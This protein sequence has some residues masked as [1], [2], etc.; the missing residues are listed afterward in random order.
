[1]NEQNTNLEN[2]KG[3][4]GKNNI[5]SSKSGKIIERINIDDYELRHKIGNNIYCNTRICKNHLTN[6]IFAM[7]IYKKADILKNKGKMI[8]HVISTYKTLSMASHPFI[9]ELKGIHCTDPISLYYLL[10]YIPGGD[11]NTLIKLKKSLP[12][13]H[14]KFYLSSLVTV[15]E[16]LHKKNIIYRNL[17]PENVLIN[18][19][20]YIKLVGFS[21]CK[22]LNE[23]LTHTLCGS[24]EYSAPEMINKSGH[25]KAVDFWGLGII[26]YEMLT[27][28]TPFID[29]D[30]MNIYHKINKG[31]VI[32]PKGTN[33]SLKM[34]IKRFLTV[35]M[36][37]RLGCSKNG[38]MEIIEQP[39]FKDF[40]WKG[41]LYRTLTPPFIPNKESSNHHFESH[42]VEYFDN[43][44]DEPIMKE[45][46]PFYNW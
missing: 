44:L 24:P 12:L 46:D 4:N 35:D 23:E 39:F 8:E 31:K 5:M 25:N 26:L 32:F 45:D 9:V 13:D 19:D 6:K 34:I 2:K 14:I 37:K 11:L 42:K 30:P 1:M 3:T 21:F 38:I 27:G 33:K 41:L 7:K 15:I 22:I 29:H 17:K 36:T 18:S 20:G 40:D 43:S 16:Y 28:L 10:E